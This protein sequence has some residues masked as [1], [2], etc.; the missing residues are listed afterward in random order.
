EDFERGGRQL[1]RRFV[2]HQLLDIPGDP[3]AGPL[4][5]HVAGH[6][7]LLD[8]ASIGGEQAGHIWREPPPTSQNSAPIAHGANHTTPR[9]GKLVNEPSPHRLARYWQRLIQRGLVT[10]DFRQA[11]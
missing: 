11:A 7:V 8:W 3:P 10:G 6:E 5:I 2:A 4:I 9:V 1:V